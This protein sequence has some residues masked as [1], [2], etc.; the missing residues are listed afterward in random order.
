M[1]TNTVKP[2]AVTSSYVY[3][4]LANTLITVSLNTTLNQFTF[5]TTVPNNN[6]FSL[7]FGPTMT[8]TDMILWQANGAT[9]SR[10]SDM[11]SRSQSTPVNDTIQNIKSTYV[12]NTNGSVT[13]TTLRN[14]T[15]GDSK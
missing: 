11:W 9:G 6:W 5:I 1:A 14:M 12:V 13:F 4:K 15:T 10:T 3:F 8:N 2:L 7:G